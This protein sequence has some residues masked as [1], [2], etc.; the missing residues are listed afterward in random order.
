MTDYGALLKTQKTTAVRF[1]TE[2]VARRKQRIRAV[3]NWILSHLDDIRAAVHAD[4]KKPYAEIDS[5]DI[6][7]ITSEIN[8]I[9]DHI[10]DWVKPKKADTPIT[11]MGLKGEIRYEPRGACLIIAPWNFPFNLCIGP[12][13]PCLAAGNTAVIKPSEITPST[14]ALVS[15]MIRE[16]FPPDEV[17]VVE[18]GPEVSE[19]LLKLP[20]DHIFFTGSPAI[21]KIVMRAAADHLT[22]VTLELGGK[23][24]AI[25]H[26][27]ARLAEAAKRIAFGKFLNNGQTCI[28][29]DHLYVHASVIDRFLPMLKKEVMDLFASEGD[30]ERSPDYGRIAS[31]KHFNRLSAW[32]DDALNNGW[33][34]ELGGARDAATRF[35]PP[36]IITGSNMDTAVMQEEIFGPILPVLVYSEIDDVMRQLTGA[37]KPLSLYVFSSSRSFCDRVARETSSGSVG[38]NEC[39]VQ[40][41]HPNLPFGG[42]NHSGMGNSHGYFGFQAFSNEKA[43]VRQ[44]P[45]FATSH[46]FHPPYRPW[47]RRLMALLFRWF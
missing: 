19:A 4:F 5:T 45:V 35:F 28:A 17:T 40:F 10:D 26:E 32:L 30:F 23:S 43:V 31:E 22:T 15:R 46:L 25:V 16:I 42:V 13:I 20:F 8:H 11:M 3:R 47:M 21:G 14:A 39:L 29:P 12:L 27:D 1:R 9:L 37:H 36:H 6:Y 18:G 2:P 24:P 34:T 44:L 7:P 33:E 38:F 41:L